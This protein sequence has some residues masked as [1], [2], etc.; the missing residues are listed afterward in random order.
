MD[1]L[2]VAAGAQYFGRANQQWTSGT[3]RAASLVGTADDNR[4]SRLSAALSFAQGEN[5]VV[6]ASASQHHDHQPSRPPLAASGTTRGGVSWTR[7]CSGESKENFADQAGRAKLARKTSIERAGSGVWSRVASTPWSWEPEG[8]SGSTEIEPDG[9]KRKG[10]IES[11]TDA[12]GEVITRAEDAAAEP[13]GDTRQG[14]IEMGTDAE[15]E[16][17]S[18]KEDAAGIADQ[19]PNKNELALQNASKVHIPDVSKSVEDS[20]Q[21][22][23]RTSEIH[24]GG[25]DDFRIK[26]QREGRTGEKVFER[27]AIK[28][29]VSVPFSTTKRQIIII[30]DRKPL[31]HDMLGV[32]GNLPL[33]DKKLPSAVAVRER[34]RAM[35]D[36]TEIS[37][38]FIRDRIN[39]GPKFRRITALGANSRSIADLKHQLEGVEEAVCPTCAVEIE[40]GLQDSF[41]VQMLLDQQETWENDGCFGDAPC[42]TCSHNHTH[43]AHA[44]LSEAADRK[45]KRAR[46]AEQAGK[47]TT[48]SKTEQPAP[49][50]EEKPQRRPDLHTRPES[51]SAWSTG[52]DESNAFLN[53]HGAD[54]QQHEDGNASMYTEQMERKGH[55]EHPRDRQ[56][57][58]ATRQGPSE[59]ILKPHP[60]EMPKNRG[61]RAS[62]GMLDNA[63]PQEEQKAAVNRKQEDGRNEAIARP[64]SGVAA[65]L[66]GASGRGAAAILSRAAT[67]LV[68]SKRQEPGRHSGA[69]EDPSHPGPASL[70][71]QIKSE[72]ETQADELLRQKLSQL[73]DTEAPLRV[74]D[75][76]PFDPNAEVVRH[77]GMEMRLAS[78]GAIIDFIVGEIERRH[79]RTQ[80][81]VLELLRT[82]EKWEWTRKWVRAEGCAAALKFILQSN[83]GVPRGK[84]ANRCRKATDAPNAEPTSV[85]AQDAATAQETEEEA[86]RPSTKLILMDPRE[87]SD[88]KV[89]LLS[90]APVAPR[91]ALLRIV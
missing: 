50:D 7:A 32:S 15:V 44:I 6:D 37:N 74:E 89:L 45:G 85:A 34:E 11:I 13:C 41:S 40:P 69:P 19:G 76:F 36:L 29:R 79:G 47:R 84:K 35:R 80:P 60:P 56:I 33:P 18:R 72:V 42:V 77:F 12:E 73:K 22:I 10:H 59:R 17:N 25:A 86:I 3:M 90:S 2:P 58:I 9:V 46:G 62:A 57:G 71:E 53:M 82:P 67:G 68:E 78:M 4:L 27:Y 20:A 26:W 70:A 87:A 1:K 5:Y 88:H 55:L 8:P 51:L 61:T 30:D 81:T 38:R 49:R 21:V 54:K 63:V 23:R 14:H 28:G 39:G 75:E 66:R 24:Q 64:R 83:L 91:F 48:M 52:D 16:K 65:P 43:T 31:T